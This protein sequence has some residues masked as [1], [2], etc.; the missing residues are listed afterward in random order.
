MLKNIK[1]Y[2]VYKGYIDYLYMILDSSFLMA[3]RVAT[4]YLELDIKLNL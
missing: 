1:N 2:E 4:I 3:F